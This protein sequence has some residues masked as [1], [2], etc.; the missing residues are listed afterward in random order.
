MFNDI[1]AAEEW[2][3]TWTASVNAQAERAAQLTSRVAALTANAESNDGSIRVTVGSTGQIEKLTLDDRVQRLSGEELARQIMNVMRKAQASLSTL[4]STE[5]AA[6]VGVD[7]ETGRAVIGS[8]EQR[9]PQPP[10]DDREE[11]RR[12]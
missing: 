1:D 6:T 2:L 4:V 10:Q 9:F 5:V 12:G 8:F 11:E 7:T 3:N